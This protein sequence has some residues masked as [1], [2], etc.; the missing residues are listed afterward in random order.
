MV[1]ENYGDLVH[2]FV[3]QWI[4]NLDIHLETTT[5]LRTSLAAQ[6]VKCLSTMWETWVQSLGP[7]DPLENKMAIHSSTISWKTHGQRNLV[8]YNPWGRKESDMTERLH[9]HFH[10]F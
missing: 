1:Y 8:G 3:T 10:R 5:D 2:G 4:L 7:E 6:I 9:F